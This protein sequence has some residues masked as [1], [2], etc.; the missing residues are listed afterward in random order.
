MRDSLSSICGPGFWPILNAYRPSVSWYQELGPV[1]EMPGTI[2]AKADKPT[3]MC[4]RSCTQ[5]ATNRNIMNQTEWDILKNEEHVINIPSHQDT[6]S[7]STWHTFY[8]LLHLHPSQLHTC[9]HFVPKVWMK[10]GLVICIK[11]SRSIWASY[12]ALHTSCYR[13]LQGPEFLSA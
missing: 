2:P 6:M 4:T 10:S 11:L 3:F 1:K 9:I 7:D 12:D 5:F 13:P 8:T